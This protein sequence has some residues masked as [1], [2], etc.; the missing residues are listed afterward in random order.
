[1]RDGVE[2][3]GGFGIGFVFNESTV[4]R[5][6]HFRH[7]LVSFFG[8]EDGE[9][10]VASGCLGVAADDTH[11]DAMERAAPKLSAGNSG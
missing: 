3:D 7:Q 10:G 2:D 6:N 8:V 1:M 4:A 5:C 9:V 11:A